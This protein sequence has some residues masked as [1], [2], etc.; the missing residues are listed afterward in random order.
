MH[1]QQNI[2]FKKEKWPFKQVTNNFQEKFDLVYKS[3]IHAET[4][5]TLPSTDSKNQVTYR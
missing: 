3:D 4:S 1:G 2:T 5:S